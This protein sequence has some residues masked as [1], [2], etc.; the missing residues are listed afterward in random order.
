MK[1]R[2]LVVRRGQVWVVAL[3]GDSVGREQP[4]TR[5][6]LV[7][8]SDRFNE[9][10][11]GLA[12]VIPMTTTNRKFFTHVAIEPPEGGV[13]RTSFIMCEQ[14]RSVS[15]ERFVDELGFVSLE[16]MSRVREVVSLLVDFD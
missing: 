11:T 14:I 8:T 4:R 6:A 7:L 13:K 12:I 3:G 15:T 10:I 16:T 9:I 1:V 5:P 2:E